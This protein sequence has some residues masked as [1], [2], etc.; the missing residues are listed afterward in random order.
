MQEPKDAAKRIA[1]KEQLRERMRRSIAEQGAYGVRQ[2]AIWEKAY[3]RAAR[4]VQ[5]QFPTQAT[6]RKLIKQIDAAHEWKHEQS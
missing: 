4:F 1:L 2:T 5:R 3:A 6:L